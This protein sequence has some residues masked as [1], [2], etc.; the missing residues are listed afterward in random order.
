MDYNM[1]LKKIKRLFGHYALTTLYQI[2][3]IEFYLL[4]MTT[5]L[6]LTLITIFLGYMPQIY[7]WI[8]TI[9]ISNDRQFQVKFKSFYRI[10]LYNVV[11]KI[12]AN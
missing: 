6:V 7:I 11:R 10:D 3:L 5:K 1:N 8:Y 2:W 4:L 12:I 9:D